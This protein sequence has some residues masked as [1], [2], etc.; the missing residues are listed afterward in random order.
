MLN[1][2][3][4]LVLSPPTPPEAPPSRPS[5]VNSSHCA[6][7]AS[8]PLS[9]GCSSLVCLGETPLRLNYP[10]KEGAKTHPHLTPTLVIQRVQCPSH[11]GWPRGSHERPVGGNSEN[12]VL[13]TW[14]RGTLFP[15]RG[16][17]PGIV[18]S[19]FPRRMVT[20]KRG[21]L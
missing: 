6:S 18:G 5:A 15:L 19:H 4:P 9:S 12:C 11:S 2:A 17:K 3:Q 16:C 10:S 13:C 14:G 1:W 21:D 7:P 20:H 8:P